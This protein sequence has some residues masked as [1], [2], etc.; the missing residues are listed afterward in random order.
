MRNLSK[1]LI[2]LLLLA[3][4][5]NIKA[6]QMPL[7]DSAFASVI[8]CGPG[9]DFY[10]TFGHS[11]IRVCDPA[12]GID[13]VYNYGTFDFNTKNFY[14]KF[15]TGRLNYCLSRRQ[16]LEYMYEYFYEK[17]AVWEQ[18]LLLTHQE[19]NNLYLALEWNYRPE[20]RYYRYDLFRDNCATRTRDMVTSA[21]A[22]RT[23]W[24]EATA[25]TNLSYRELIYPL[26][27][28]KL[29]WWRL[30]CDLLMG[31]R[32]DKRCSNFEYMFL[33]MQLMNQLDTT[34]FADTHRPFA[35]K[36]VQIL[37]ETKDELADS[38]SP[39]ILF[40][41]L[42]VVVLCFTVIGWSK[43]WPMT[44]LDAVLFGVVGLLSL[45]ILAMWFGSAHYCTK[46]NFNLLWAS[47]LFIYFAIALRRS[48][49]WI[50]IAQIV[51]LV[52]ALLILVTGWPQHFNAAVTPIALTLFV[53]L[54]NNL[55]FNNNK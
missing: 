21:L 7:S 54:I 25:D 28:R 32:C 44:W 1:I 50:V 9:N 48:N 38:L 26:M 37:P 49:R 42:F 2:C 20:N 24:T 35:A 51:M 14:L 13:S 29:E 10:T 8:T 27:D 15:A 30:G 55:R 41:F 5:Q 23:L 11:A 17:R 19:L 52:A 46:L 40:W 47:P 16:Y 39:T 18:P 36:T 4:L 53:R 22:H 31:A 6:Q 33:P 43:R 45:F 12:R 34:T 3:P